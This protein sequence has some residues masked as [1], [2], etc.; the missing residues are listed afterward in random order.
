MGAGQW[1]AP[2]DTAFAAQRIREPHRGLSVAVAA[3]GLTLFLL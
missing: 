1:L 2:S 3:M